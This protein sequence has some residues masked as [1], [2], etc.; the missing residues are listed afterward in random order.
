[1][2]PQPQRCELRYLPLFW[3]DLNAAVSCIADTLQNPAAATRLLDQVEKA[4]LDHAEAPT[5]AATYKTTRSRP[6]PYYWFAVGNYLVF[7]VMFDDIME[8]RRFL[9]GARNLSHLLP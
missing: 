3:D 2:S 6:L 9:H 7:Y 8:V 1:M 5:A 4:I